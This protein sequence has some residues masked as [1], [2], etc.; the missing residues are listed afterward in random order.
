MAW[1]KISKRILLIIAFILSISIYIVSYYQLINQ[2]IRV[3]YIVKSIL[4]PII[5]IILTYSLTFA[6]LVLD[7][8]VCRKSRTIISI[9]HLIIISVSVL[10]IN[11]IDITNNLV[12]IINNGNLDLTL[13]GIIHMLSIGPSG[14]QTILAFTSL[15]TSLLGDICLFLY[16]VLMVLYAIRKSEKTILFCI[17]YMC[18]FIILCL[19]SLCFSMLSRNINS[20]VFLIGIFI[21][22]FVLLPSCI[23]NKHSGTASVITGSNSKDENHPDK[24]GNDTNSNYK[25]LEMYKSKR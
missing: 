25:Y 17:T 3:T 8:K 5:I 18:A 21:R 15:L 22:A 10:A 14:G 13:H 2:N 9:I 12:D 16:S 19:P 11:I 7:D 6:F 20:L 24:S 1:M 4:Y 23:I